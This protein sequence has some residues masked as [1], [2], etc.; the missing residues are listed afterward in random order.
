M[1]FLREIKIESKAFK[2]DKNYLKTKISLLIHLRQ[3]EWGQCLICVD[4]IYW[5]T[6]WYSTGSAPPPM[7]FYPPEQEDTPRTYRSDASNVPVAPK[8]T[9]REMDSVIIASQEIT[10]CLTKTFSHY[11]KAIVSV[12]GWSSVL[13]VSFFVS[14]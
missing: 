7:Y 2:L 4:T 6:L 13:R 8:Q 3:D 9:Q 1:H 10:E 5:L 11:K 12:Y 14:V